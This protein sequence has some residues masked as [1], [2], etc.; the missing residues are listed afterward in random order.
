M[1]ALLPPEKVE[2]FCRRIDAL[3]PDAEARFGKMN[4][5]QMLCHCADLLRV[6][7]GRMKGRNYGERSPAEVLAFI[8]A[9]QTVPTP[10]GFD[11]VAGDGTPPTEFEADRTMLQ[12]LLQTFAELPAD[13]DYPPH[14]Y[15][16]KMN[17]EEWIKAVKQH[18]NHHLKQFGV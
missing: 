1:L 11:Q 8:K 14:P 5:H 9:G 4:P 12:Q 16:G 3:T 13:Y 6:A 17:R 7:L 15:W 10:D 2:I 18:T